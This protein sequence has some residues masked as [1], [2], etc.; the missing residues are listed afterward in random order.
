V[1]QRLTDIQ[2]E[3]VAS[4]PEESAVIRDTGAKAN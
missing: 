4:A 1:R 3:I 2:F